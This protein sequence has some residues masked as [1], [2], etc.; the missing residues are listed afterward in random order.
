MA[1]SDSPKPARKLQTS[2]PVTPLTIDLRQVLIVL[3]T[4]FWVA[5]GLTLVVCS[6][7]AW[8]QLSRP[9]LYSADASLFFERPARVQ[10]LRQLQDSPMDEMQISTRREQ[11]RSVE[12]AQRVANSFTPEEVALITGAP[13]GADAAANSSGRGR[14]LANLL[15]R[16][17]SADRRP[18]TMLLVV[19][20]VHTDPRAAALMA[21]R[22]A[23]Q[24]IRYVF[25]RSAAGNDA[26]LA[27][28]KEQAE[29]LRKKVE[30][31]ERDLQDYRQRFH[32]VSLEANQNIV[33]DNLKTLNANNTAARVARLAAEARL[34]Q[35]EDLLKREASAEQMASATGFE[36]L[37]DLAKRLAELQAKR[38]VMAERYG[39]RHPA[40]QESA[41][42][43]EALKKVRDERVQLA[44]ASL[45]DQVDKARTVEKQLA[46]QLAEAEKE[47][48]HLDQIGVEYN[49]LRRNADSNRATYTQILARL[50]DATISAQLTGVNVKISELATPPGAPFSPNPRRTLLLTLALGLSIFIGY[51]FAMEL[52]FGRIR[53]VSDVEHFLNTEVL[54]EI[55]AVRKIADHE[56]AQLVRS[57]ANEAATEQFR[58][59]YSHLLLSS[60]I[61]PPKTILV[62][63][64]LPSEGK[65][66]IAANLAQLFV[67]HGRRVLLIDGDFRRPVQHR[68][69]SLPNNAGILAWLSQN[70]PVGPDVLRDSTLG[71]HEIAPCL[72]VLRAGGSSRKATELLS[73]EVLPRL[74]EELQ[75]HFD[76]LIIDTPPAGVFPDAIAFAKLSHESVFVCRFNTATRQTVRSVIER[77]RQADI[78]TPGVVLN[79]MPTGL[80]GSGYYY[81]YA[82]HQAKGYGKAYSHPP[83]KDA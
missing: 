69:F 46:D 12:L 83:E 27:F 19:S 43:I 10:E 59:L 71:I 31:S 79:A 7:V 26:A 78:E 64:T 61:D 48:L 34:A 6:F 70:R 54:G 17:V 77:F 8:Q 35:A 81:G 25:D 22:Y 58:A 11:L 9:K 30:A 14:D 72:H 73:G 76:V 32:L 5:A 62:T 18:E 82:Y 1:R 41:R 21:N 75:R 80:G 67:A 60:R 37:G 68:N 40:M 36:S 3:R 45:R 50:N 52:F 66:F 4:H 29:E 63:S 55:G 20:A 38:A 49:T 42:E 23:E 39:L 2:A 44:I 47:S 53:S 65:S 74:I 28:L 33:V 51:P 24:F 16:S 15:R 56:R 13:V 57:E